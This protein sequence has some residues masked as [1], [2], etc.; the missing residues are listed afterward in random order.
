[1]VKSYI[2][3]TLSEALEILSLDSC[4]IVAGGTDMM[5]Q[6]RSHK[7]LPV[8]YK[9]DVVYVNLINEL[10]FIREDESWIHIGA[11]TRL[12]DILNHDLTPII[13][14]KIIH[15]MASPAIRHTATL[16]GNIANASPAG[17]SLVGLYALDAVIKVESLN[18]SRMVPIN[19]FI[20]GVRKIDLMPNEMITAVMIP[21]K[22]FQGVFFKKV[23]PRLSD[24]ISKI[25]IVGLKTFEHGKLLDIRIALGAVYKTVVRLPAIEKK[26]IGLSH[27]DLVN[28][29]DSIVEE[30]NR[31]IQPIDDQRSNKTY[32]RMVS[33]NLIREFIIGEAGDSL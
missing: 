25:S 22:D 27:Q 2:A 6:N 32:R 5:I 8:G 1:M 3:K 21:K 7:G 10:S 9:N 24:A 12:E 26:M 18:H 20:L 13:L 29:I 4:Q 17:D 30:Y 31:V 28:Q 33:L 23:A 16:A 19:D 14:K 15:E 11:T